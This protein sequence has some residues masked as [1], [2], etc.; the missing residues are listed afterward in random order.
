MERLRFA[1]WN[2]RLIR[3]DEPRQQ[4]LACEVVRR[5]IDEA[6][7][8]LLA[9]GEVTEDQAEMLRDA[10]RTRPLG[11]LAGDS[12]PRGMALCYRRDLLRLHGHERITTEW[13]GP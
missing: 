10:C 1:W 8:V 6:G 12:V 9:L 2:T 5:L 13:E 4:E 11:L 3:R 7:V